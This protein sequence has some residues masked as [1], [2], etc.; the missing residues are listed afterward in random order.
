MTPT[1]PAAAEPGS[2]LVV[3]PAVPDDV[4]E[5]AA[6]LVA[7]RRAAEPAM[8]PMQADEERARGFL[9]RHIEAGEVWVA[10]EDRIVGFAIISGPWLHSL[11]V[12]PQHQG[13]G[14]GSVLLDLVKSQRP[15]GFGLWVFEAN[16]PARAFYRRHGLIELEHTDG[17]GNQER[18]PD[19]RMAW[20]GADPTAYLRA[21]IDAVDDDLA[22]LLARR[23]ALTAAIQGYKQPR[24]HAGRDP[25]REREIAVRMAAHAP[26]LELDRVARVLD[27]VISEGL[28]QWEQSR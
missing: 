4:A 28:D 1:E 18:T 6:L 25:E 2:D 3:R 27:A 20:P 9:G 5:V 11:Y 19:L 15:D 24:G 16:T 7:T 23:F 8:P 17:A 26:G 10:E 22:L 14:I 21:E 12:G 13:T